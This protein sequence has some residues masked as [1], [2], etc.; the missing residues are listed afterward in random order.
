MLA[1]VID[2]SRSKRDLIAANALLRQQLT[3]LKRQSQ[4]PRLTHM[5]RLSLLIFARMA[6][7]WR[8]VLRAY[9]LQYPALSWPR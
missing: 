9:D 6:K 8:Q 4:R 3:M 1:S 7:T 5:D 2:L